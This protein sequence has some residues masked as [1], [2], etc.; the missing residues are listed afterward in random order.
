MGLFLLFAPVF[1]AIPLTAYNPMAAAAAA[2]AVVRGTNMFFVLRPTHDLRSGN[3]LA[4]KCVVYR[5]ITTLLF[6]F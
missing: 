1:I 2:A 6:V 4:P 5:I 3:E